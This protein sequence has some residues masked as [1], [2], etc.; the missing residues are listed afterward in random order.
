MCCGCII[1]GYLGLSVVVPFAN[2]INW[3]RPPQP[4][5]K[6]LNHFLH[7]GEYN[8]PLSH[9]RLHLFVLRPIFIFREYN[10][11]QAPRPSTCFHSAQPMASLSLQVVCCVEQHIL[12]DHQQKVLAWEGGTKFSKESL[13]QILCNAN[14]SRILMPEYYLF[15]ELTGLPLTTHEGQAYVQSLHVSSPIVG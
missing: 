11:T 2:Q 12:S 15:E 14:V 5:S 9:Q 3:A 6:G 13:A 7:W 10:A 1:R 4:A 8:E